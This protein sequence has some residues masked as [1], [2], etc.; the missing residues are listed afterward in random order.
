[1]TPV[2]WASIGKDVVV[3]AAAGFTA[4][5]AWRGLSKWRS[6]TKGRARFETARDLIRSTYDLRD[7]LAEAR[8]PMITVGEYPDDYDSST[9]QGRGDGL[10]HVYQNRW[11]RV[12][13]AWDSFRDKAA[14]AEVLFGGEI[15]ELTSKLDN[16]AVKVRAAMNALISNEHREGRDF[17]NDREFGR[18]IHED[19]YSAKG[20]I[21]NPM[22]KKIIDSV[23]AIVVKLKNEVE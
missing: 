4:F 10:A 7:D 11:K 22:T 16:C 2:E 5:V 13:T 19:V 15:R 12:Q 3:P 18:R 9:A 14:E 20:D 23:N 17:D 6:E 8:V 21:D 1:M